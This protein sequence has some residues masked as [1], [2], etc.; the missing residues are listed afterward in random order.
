M[1]SIRKARF[2][3]WVLIALNAIS[4]FGYATY[5]LN[6]ELLAQSP[7]AARIFG[8]S[9]AFF[10]RAQILVAFFATAFLLHGSVG[11]RWLPS[12]YWVVGLSLASE[13]TGVAFGV[14]FGRYSYTDL[15]GPKILEVPVLIPMSWYF[16]TIACLRIAGDLD[17][18]RTSAF[19]RIV[20]AASLLSAWD[21]TLDPAMSNLSPFWVWEET[22]I[23]YG[24]PL[25]NLFGWFVTG[26]VLMAALELTQTWKW[27]DRISPRYAYAFYGANLMLPVG[28]VLC[29]KL[30]G[31]LA[32]STV[33]YLLLGIW[34][35]ARGRKGAALL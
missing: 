21:L 28:L 8:Y 11:W 5:S 9:Y 35:K 33:A 26:L 31:P 2:L 34:A 4:I 3:F 27:L 32:V 14:P 16:M 18:K 24:S 17:K 12:L 29:S 6:P 7:W 22:G 23:Y 15:L 13:V 25:L 30:F 20:V 19:F 1:P 10:A